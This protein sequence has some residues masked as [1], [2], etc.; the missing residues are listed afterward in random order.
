MSKTVWGATIAGL[1]ILGGIGFYL[2][3]DELPTNLDIASAPPDDSIATLAPEAPPP[4]QYPVPETEP[5]QV[6]QAVDL[7]DSPP[8]GQSPVAIQAAPTAAPKA[9]KT[10]PRE[11]GDQRLGRAILRLFDRQRIEQYL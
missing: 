11:N 5:E 6:S 4:I 7:I 8:P 3:R 1:A 9:K 10:Q 2:Y